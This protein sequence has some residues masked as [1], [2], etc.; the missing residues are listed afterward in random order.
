[1]HDADEPPLSR[2]EAL[3][4]AVDWARGGMTGARVRML[5]G[6]AGGTTDGTRHRR[7]TILKWRYQLSDRSFSANDSEIGQP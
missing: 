1:M 5:K 3:M 6:S 2:T 7:Q 4:G